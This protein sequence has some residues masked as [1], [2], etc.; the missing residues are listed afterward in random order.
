MHNAGHIIGSAMVELKIGEK[1]ILFSGDMGKKDPL[2]LYPPKKIDHVDYLVLEST[3]GDREHETVDLKK[4][5]TSVILET[6]N[7][8]GILMIPAFAV[9]RTQEIIFL[10]HQLR[11]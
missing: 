10:L 9:E 7:R 5:L 6:Y 1:K 11:G 8:R 2:L 3:Y 4:E